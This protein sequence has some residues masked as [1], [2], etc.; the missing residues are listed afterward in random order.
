MDTKNNLLACPDIT[1]RNVLETESLANIYLT[2]SATYC[3]S[4]NSC[5]TCINSISN[6]W[7]TKGENALGVRGP[8]ASRTVPYP[9]DRSLEQN[10]N[11]ATSTDPYALDVR[12]LSSV[13]SR[14][15]EILQKICSETAMRA[16]PARERLV[17][18]PLTTLKESLAIW[19]E[20]SMVRDA[21]G[22][23]PPNA[24]SP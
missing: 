19:S 1:I 11:G 24:F 12:G 21:P 6:C 10:Q 16:S 15:S 18:T 20:I 7:L 4:G 3:K 17:G 2:K 9:T 14:S 22:P 8:G 23:R 5:L 13:A